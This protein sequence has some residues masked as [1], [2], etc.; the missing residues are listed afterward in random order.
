MIRRK[1]A[2]L[3]LLAGTL[4][5]FIS[6][7]GPA[8]E[9]SASDGAVSES[10]VPADA[11]EH[12][13]SRSGIDAASN[14]SMD[15]SAEAPQC[16]IS[17]SNYDQSCSVDSD[18][19]STVVI[20]DAGDYVFVKSG[21]YCK[22]MCNCGGDT[23]SRD[24]VGKYTSDMLRTPLGSGAIPRLRCGCPAQFLPCCRSGTCL[25]GCLRD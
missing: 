14:G 10:G 22:S 15:G 24:A 5:G 12:A 2:T 11:S 25:A 7:T 23:I 9:S 21:D 16:I 17:T 1:T 6:C 8:R 18:C 3:L 4:C 20:D 13:D 19:V